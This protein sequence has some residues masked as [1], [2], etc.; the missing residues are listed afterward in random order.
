MVHQ[1]FW[2]FLD[3]PKH[4]MEIR[5]IWS[6]DNSPAGGCRHFLPLFRLP[7]RLSVARGKNPLYSKKTDLPILLLLSFLPW[8]HAYPMFAIRLCHFT[9]AHMPHLH[10]SASFWPTPMPSA[11]K[12]GHHM[13]VPPLLLFFGTFS[14]LLLL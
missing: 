4:S 9:P 10:L 3:I 2:A 5:L 1:L 12:C 7:Y 11:S 6:Q 8:T 14:P 13:W